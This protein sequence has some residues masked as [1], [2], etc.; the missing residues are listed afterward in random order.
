MQNNLKYRDRAVQDLLVHRQTKTANMVKA[1]FT[2]LNLNANEVGPAVCRLS[3]GI[4]ARFSI[5][6]NV[7]RQGCMT[8]WPDDDHT[9][10]Y[11]RDGGPIWERPQ[12][13]DGRGRDVRRKLGG[14]PWAKNFDLLGVQRVPVHSTAFCI[15]LNQDARFVFQRG[16]PIAVPDLSV[17]ENCDSLEHDVQPFADEPVVAKP[18]PGVLAPKGRFCRRRRLSP[19]GVC[20]FWF[21][22]ERAG[23]RRQR[24][25]AHEDIMGQELGPVQLQVSTVTSSENQTLDELE[26]AYNG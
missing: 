21:W 9:L 1:N 3:V 20:W 24:L 19:H 22:R 11:Q 5:P 12:R 8:A 18:F 6:P 2:S 14:T 25:F 4:W 26:V 7:L 10:R 15:R 23:Q 13:F 17:V 16:Q